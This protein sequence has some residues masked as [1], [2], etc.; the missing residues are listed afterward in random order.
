MPFNRVEEVRARDLRSP[1]EMM[2]N[3]LSSIVGTLSWAHERFYGEVQM[4][5]CRTHIM[6]KEDV[7]Q[8]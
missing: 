8:M 3:K 7:Q 5:A 1:L 6:Q 4:E 2:E